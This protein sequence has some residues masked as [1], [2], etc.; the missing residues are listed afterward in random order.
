MHL[1]SLI[2]WLPLIGAVAIACLPERR[3]SWIRWTAGGCSAVV[4]ALASALP[5]LFDADDR[6][7]QLTEFQSWNPG[8]GSAY[9]LGLDGLS[10]PMA[11]LTALLSFVAVLVSSKI[12]H[13]PK[14]YHAWLLVLETGMLGVFLAQ[15]W[16]LLYLFWEL[17]LI[18]LFLLIDR[19][20]GVRRQRA[21]LTFV[22]YTM[23][24]AIFLL[25]SLLLLYQQGGSHSST[26]AAMRRRRQRCRPSSNS[27]YSSASSP[28]SASRCRSFPCTAGCP[29]PTWKR[30]APSASCCR[31]CC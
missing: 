26:M 3:L 6:G 8:L 16:T 28:A 31:A 19:W 15:D 2:L 13:A 20:G 9:A 14:S 5:A 17:T 11:L 10:L 7:M 24:G 21:S 23:G 18:P 12:K 22:I 30:P 29:W 4:L 1:L 27:G 25:I